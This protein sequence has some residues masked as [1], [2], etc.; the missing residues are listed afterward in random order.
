VCLSVCNAPTF[1][2]LDLERTL[3]CRNT[4]RMSRS[5]LYIK[6]N[7]TGANKCIC[8]LN[9]GGLPSTGRL[10]PKPAHSWI[11]A[12]FR[13]EARFQLEQDVQ[14]NLG[15]ALL[16][17]GCNSIQVTVI[18]WTKPAFLASSLTFSSCLRVQ[19]DTATFLTLP[20]SSAS[21]ARYLS[22]PVNV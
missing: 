13:E 18:H 12:E 2:S 19:S 10:F 3:E 1:Q 22:S 17:T 11:L 15:T 21:E 7:I 16:I 5:S 4:F 8:I 14:P 9:A 20:L 6:I